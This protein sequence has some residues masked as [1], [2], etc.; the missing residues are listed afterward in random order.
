MTKQSYKSKRLKSKLNYNKHVV[1]VHRSNKNIVAQILAP[2]S[3][4]TLFTSDSVTITKGTKMEK[5]SIVG[6][7]I[8]DYL[9]KKKI[10]EVVFD[11]N[12]FV[13]TG[14]IKAFAESLRENNITM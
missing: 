12:G 9:I 13:Y 5:S 7:S 10:T 8:A 14:R 11:R 2:L 1:V 6:K 3:K 4:S